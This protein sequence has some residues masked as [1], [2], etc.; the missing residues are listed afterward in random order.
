MGASMDVRL[1]EERV[2]VLPD[3]FNM[4]IAEARAQVRRVDAFGTLAKMAGLVGK[5]RAEEIELIY[6]ERRLQPY[7]ALACTAVC[8]YERSR[9][10]TLKLPPEVTEVS[11]GGD[12][13]AVKAQQAQIQ[14]LE[15]CRQELRK[16]AVFD[17]LSGA[18][19]ADLTAS[20]RSAARRVEPEAL[21]TLSDGT[22]IV[23]P[24]IKAP[25]VIRDLL[26]TLGPKIEA[27]RL[28]EETVSFEQIDL[29]Y[30]PV[31]AFRFRRAGKEAVVEVDGVTG[32]ARLGGSTFEA[33]LG[34]MLEPKFLVEVGA[35]TLNL[36]L[37]G[38][39][40]VKV[41]ALKG[42]EMTVRK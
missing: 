11:I 34:K 35:E 4:D 14:V 28:V 1:T 40:L 20:A 36:F 18:K 3:Y 5:V 16:E 32:E 24:Q 2:L 26:A 30:R 41:L 31:Y 10:H 6:K 8:T 9:R 19:A 37:P 33:Y 23:P 38:A 22:V 17:A 27:D 7:W 42:M 25:V 12:A 21:S 29:Y 39:T 13:Y 15:N